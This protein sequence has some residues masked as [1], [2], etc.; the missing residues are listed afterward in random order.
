[1]PSPEMFEDQATHAESHVSLEALPPQSLETSEP[2]RI[3]AQNEQAAHGAPP[4]RAGF[5]FPAPL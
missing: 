5:D 2:S 4:A 1:M 3:A